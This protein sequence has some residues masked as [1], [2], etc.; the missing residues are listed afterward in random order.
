V[1]STWLRNCTVY[2]QPEAGHECVLEQ[3]TQ[4]TCCRKNPNLVIGV[5]A[6]DS[7]KK[8]L[9][10][11]EGLDGTLYFIGHRLLT[12]VEKCRV[13]CLCNQ[14]YTRKPHRSLM[15]SKDTSVRYS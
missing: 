4:G 9:L 10:F 3:I 8:K 11:Q 5:T 2:L 15:I 13:L 1:S 12:D 14:G 6:H 7:M